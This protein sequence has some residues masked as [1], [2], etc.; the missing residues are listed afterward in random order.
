MEEDF[1]NNKREEAFKFFPKCLKFQIRI[2]YI[3]LR[4]SLM[5]NWDC[6]NQ[7]FHF[8]PESLN[9]LQ[10]FGPI[11]TQKDH[12]NYIESS[13]LV[14]RKSESIK[15]KTHEGVLLKY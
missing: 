14:P 2:A 13:F 4:N 8:L 7:Y 15:L 12:L 6:N 3:V 5:K 1:K 11:E 9:N 10:L